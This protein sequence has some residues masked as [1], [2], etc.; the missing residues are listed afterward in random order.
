MP[1]DAF[2]SYSSLDKAA[3]NAACAALEAAGIRCWI[4]PRDILPGKEWGEAIIEA[5]NGS[6]VLVLIFSANANASPQIRRE[7]ER[8]V[9]KGIPIVPLRIEDIVPTHALEY[10]I[11]TVHWLDALTPPLE[12]H[13][14]RLTESVKAL[15]QISP[16]PPRILAENVIAAPP[17]GPVRKLLF[18][19]V[20]VAACFGIGATVIGTWWLATGRGSAPPAA[21]PTSAAIAQ[22]AARQ[23]PPVIA[24]VP[25]TQ[26]LVGTFSRTGIV[27]GYSANFVYALAADGTY[28]STTRLEES[29]TFQGGNGM[30]RT[31]STTGTVRTGTYHAVG[32]NAIE[33]INS[34]GSAAVFRPDEPM[35]PV[36]LANPVMLGRWR[37][38]VTKDGLSWTWIVQN[39]TDATFVA[40]G[41]SQD[42]GTCT[43]AA[44]QWR[45]T[46]AVSGRSSAGTYRILDPSTIE[47]TN[48]D[49][50]TVWQRAQ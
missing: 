45:C 20:I 3:A 40:D 37:A 18:V 6:H 11:G 26:P 25:V 16:T 44:A 2:I 21:S 7:V 38:T 24:A 12:N 29:G 9:H 31:V 41:Q 22:P 39:N 27:D 49:V 19:I 46:S 34:K 4:A 5:I 42:K 30:Y 48:G 8:A 36:D 10:F 43:L 13:L 15:L 17:A 32:P 23:A 1:H 14:R 28:Q 33:L 47:I 50:S 35:P